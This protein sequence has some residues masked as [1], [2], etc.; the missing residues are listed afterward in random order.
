MIAGARRGASPTDAELR[1][2]LAISVEIRALEVL[3]K[4]PAAPNHL[5]E[6]PARVVVLVVQPEVFG[7]RVDAL[8]QD[9][10]LDL[11]R[12]GVRVVAAMLA[13]DLLLALLGEHDLSFSSCPATSQ[14]VAAAG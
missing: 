5:Q 10:D 14:L 3:Q 2:Q 12:A 13:D 7:E 11:W 6:A 4:A 8:G 1:G 9:C